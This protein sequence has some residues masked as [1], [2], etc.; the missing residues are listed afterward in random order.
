MAATNDE[1]V[2]ALRNSV[3]E[4]ARLRA[5]NESTLRA[6]SEPIA[7]VGM[8]CR[9]PGDVRS[10]SDLWS[11]VAGGVDAISG[12]P[13]DRGWD[14]QGLC[15]EDPD[16]LG[17][18]YVHEGGF[19]EDATLFDADFFGL[20]P[21]EVLAMDPQQ[22]LLLEASWEALEDAALD[23]RSLRASQTAVF[24]GAGAQDYAVAPP[25]SPAT[26]Q[27]EGYLVTGRAGSVVSGRVAH[28][29]GFEGAAVTVDTACSSSLVALHL[30][31]QALR[32]QECSLALAGGV[33]VLASPT[34]FV[35][36]SRQRGLAPD[37]R[38]KSF[39]Q[40]AD[41]TGWS[42]GVGV[43]V[44]ERLSDAQASG[45][46]ILAMVR[47]SA[48]NQDGASNGLTAPNGPSQQR[49]I[50]RALANAGLSA[51][52]IDA[53][54]AHGTGT[55]LGD[56]IEAQALI[57]TYG[58]DRDR[59]LWLG[60]IKSNIGHCIAAAG[61]AGV[62]KMVEALRHGVLPRTLHID[63]PTSH[64]DWSAG[65]VSLLTESVEWQPNGAP[66][67]AGISSFGISGTNAHLIIEEAPPAPPAP[68]AKTWAITPA[69]QP[70]GE[71]TEAASVAQGAAE[72]ELARD[73]E[74]PVSACVISGRSRL[75]LRGQALRLLERIEGDHDL[76]IPDVGLSLASRSAF[77]H[78][79]VVIA[80]SR[81]ELL[82]GLG[83]VA[84][85]ERGLPALNVVEGVGHGHRTAFLFTGQGAQRPGMGNELYRSFSV[86]RSAF[87][88]LCGYFDDL[89]GRSLRD[90]V[91]TDRPANAGLLDETVFTQAALFALEVS[92]FRLLESFDVRP[93]FLIGHSIGE[94]AAAHVA[95]VFSLEDACV[96]VAARG[97]LMGALPAGGAM[98]SIEAGEDEVLQTLVGLE[99]TVALAA[100]NGPASVVISGE[101]DTVLEIAERWEQQGRKIKRLRVSHAF[102]SPR[103]EP[104][105]AE[106][107]DVAEQI[108][109][110]APR[111]PV[112]SNVS[113][114]PLSTREIA[115]AD[116]WV[117]HVREP[118]RFC[119]GVRYLAGQAVNL[120]VELGPDG[121]LSAMTQAS[122]TVP[123]TSVEGELAA[124][125]SDTDTQPV[126]VALLRRERPEAGTLVGA[127]A[128]L[129]VR[130]ANVD[131]A[132]LF[133][134]SD[135]RL[136]T[137]PTYA[138]QRS[139]YWLAPPTDQYDGA[140]DGLRPGGHP[141][142]SGAIALADDHGWLFTGRL[143]PATQ[144][145][146]GDHVVLG[147]VVVPGAALL[148]LAL[149]AG[150]EVGCEHVGELNLEAPLVLGEQHAVA[151]QVTVGELD[152]SGQRPLGIYS[153]PLEQGRGD[154]QPWTRHASGHLCPPLAMGERLE[155]ARE[156][157]AVLADD[158]WPPPAAQALDVESFYDHMTAMGFDYGPAFLGVRSAWRRGDDVF[159]EVSLD[160]DQQ[161]QA[162]GFAVHPALL[163]AALQTASSLD[164][165]SERQERG[166][167]VP[168]AF[169]HA[170]LHEHGASSLRVALSSIAKQTPAG[171]NSKQPD[172]VSLVLGDETGRLVGALD[173]VVRAISP[174]DLPGQEDG[175]EAM[176]RLNWSAVPVAGSPHAQARWA[177][178]GD[179]QSSLAASL[180]AAEPLLELYPHLEAIAESVA[181]LDGP[182][183]AVLVDLGTLAGLAEEGA[184]GHAL[185]DRLRFTT[186]S[187]LA[188][189]KTWLADERLA[190]SRLVM[191]TRGALASGR[192]EQLSGRGEQLSGLAQSAVWGLVRSAQSENPN[193]FGLIDID[194]DAC[195]EDVLAA[196][197][198]EEPQLALRGGVVLV[199]RL[200]RH[201]ASNDTADDAHGPMLDAHGTVL[202]TGG[203]G[204]LG[205]LLAR[206]LVVEHRVGHLLLVSRRGLDAPGA[207]DLCRELQGLGAGVTVA[208]CDV[209]DR[210]ALAGLLDSIPDERP[211]CGVVHTAGVLDDGVIESL[212]PE[213][214]DRV[215]AGKADGAWY[216]HELTEH[217]DLSMFVLFSSAA[218]TIGSP[219]QANYAA[220]NAFLDA[221]ANHRHARG[222]TA[223]SMGW[224]LWR[225]ADG[226]SA[227]LSDADRAR[228]ERSGV[229]ALEPQR[230]LGLLDAAM[231]AGEPSV[232]ALALDHAALRAQA[233]AGVLPRLFSSLVRLPAS[234]PGAK[235][236]SLE[237]RLLEAPESARKDLVHELVCGQVAAVLGHSSARA[238]D[239]QRAFRDLGFDSLA[240]VELR[241]RLNSATALNLP[242]T[243][244]FDYPTPWAV[245]GYVLG[246]LALNAHAAIAPGDAQ[247]DAVEL[248][249]ASLDPGDPERERLAGR[250]RALLS[251][252]ADAQVVESDL[253]EASADELFAV[254]DRELGLA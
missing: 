214:L 40:A 187:A 21:R 206:H 161:D 84:A 234:R 183:L 247:I 110:R 4:V 217:L 55:M 252:A 58:Q 188:L 143:S 159:A 39:A 79:A 248:T 66:R 15:A 224:G 30:A 179:E 111:I 109:F 117:R 53:V 174:A 128:E 74:S 130:G 14:L 35:D 80:T 94:L 165:T 68:P 96:L 20:S 42:E 34:M 107:R 52:E 71:D 72:G 26:Q 166:L 124:P 5:D 134:H 11:L 82:A 113:G 112:I 92:L 97:R 3:R 173:M 60:S 148:E 204:G 63:E 2:V 119:K 16:S 144:T 202:V 47:G 215:F 170:T 236:Q 86:F 105:L 125:G 141:L 76:G 168:F 157:A 48:L 246:Q 122:L 137:L 184:D 191:V 116:Y 181:Q 221:L 121:V 249:M 135:A 1:L 59:P 200:E 129:W 213:R 126:A 43:L 150:R 83:E 36:F 138:F 131:W 225:Q 254:I 223:S 95:G 197:G 10:P 114:E 190:T 106:F 222:L 98:V 198:L 132:R 149:H 24:S 67:R 61:V 231:C 41:G 139:R 23:P 228:M 7:I 13:S 192:G 250:L 28:H 102:H 69:N 189:V 186:R 164:S 51:S 245:A 123:A 253:A 146:L 103:M 78:R 205:G 147:R 239:E 45:R 44:L 237:R 180:R 9:F 171:T 91:L 175:P 152:P 99:R 50:R 142:L 81:E 210:A 6:A 145:W 227:T 54:E 208:V 22:R 27:V 220:A 240:A 230:A 242:Q 185:P 172:G 243:L 65:A 33:T 46:R 178:L 169:N 238:V 158:S 233:R 212:T 207:G 17:T 108:E 120:F 216:L 19:L 77:E 195:G 196:L 232:L 251:N 118:V 56:P 182:P 88:E 37:G 209:S 154:E 85:P 156:R 62:I 38:C 70:E 140:V 49:V 18:S 244:I 201:I 104:M 162:P 151:L 226:M 133:E 25:G 8:S 127:L 241:N 199:P 57:E 219:G 32:S 235:P 73:P 229:S 211:L 155:A 115:S 64:V 100:V 193:R 93:D 31:S 203:T 29:F 163:D 101:E 136:V 167:R 153:R 75:A 176:L 87:G 89:L 177:L 90:L 218:A 194:D 160:G 12:F